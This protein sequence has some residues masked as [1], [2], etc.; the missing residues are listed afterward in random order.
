MP[1]MRLPKNE[2]K[3]ELNILTPTLSEEINES[4]LVRVIFKPYFTAKKFQ[5]VINPNL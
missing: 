4:F 5:N 1:I 3:Y 2:K